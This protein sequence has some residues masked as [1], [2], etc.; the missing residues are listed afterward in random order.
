M[1]ITYLEFRLVVAAITCPTRQVGAA[2]A[3]LRDAPCRLA[4]GVI[5]AKWP[6]DLAGPA[7]TKTAAPKQQGRSDRDG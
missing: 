1:P 6:A 2:G 4:H 5:G 7:P 3:E